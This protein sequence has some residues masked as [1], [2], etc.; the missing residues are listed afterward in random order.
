MLGCFRLSKI[1][2]PKYFGAYDSHPLYNGCGGLLVLTNA[3]KK[4]P[5]RDK[6]RGDFLYR[7]F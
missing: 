4:S 6:A 7:Y 2:V 5:R 3:Y 1:R